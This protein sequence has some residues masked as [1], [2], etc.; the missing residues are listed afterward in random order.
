L[1]VSLSRGNR[2]NGSFWEDA[3]IRSRRPKGVSRQSQSYC[4]TAAA[5]EEG[6][7][8]AGIVNPLTFLLQ[9]VPIDRV[10]AEIFG[11]LQ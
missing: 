1:V 2:F 8:P 5:D 10:E 3:T 11:E 9:V 4:C 7:K 6:A